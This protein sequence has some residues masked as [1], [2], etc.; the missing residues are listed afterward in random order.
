MEHAKNTIGLLLLIILF[1]S[2]MSCSDSKIR[3]LEQQLQQKD[4]EYSRLND[5]FQSVQELNDKQYEELITIQKELSKLDSLSFTFRTFVERRERASYTMQ[6]EIDSLISKIKDDIKQKNELIGNQSKT[7]MKLRILLET[8]TTQLET[9][10]N[11]INQLKKVVKEQGK[12]ISIQ[13]NKI[14]ELENSK[15][16]LSQQV[17]DLERKRKDLEA[18]M[19]FIQG[20]SYYNIGIAL[21]N[22]AANIPELSGIFVSGAK[23]DEVIKTKAELIRRSREFFQKSASF[24][25]PKAKNKL[26]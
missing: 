10:E 19:Q 2:N 13:N 17:R 14:D 11:E 23:K 1:L 20:E 12:T 4:E 16:N 26:N 25:Y 18:D 5:D 24:G 7:E 21:E 8:I 22:A 3:V 6:E 15:A 9:K